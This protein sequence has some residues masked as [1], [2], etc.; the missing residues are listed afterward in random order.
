MSFD[1]DRARQIYRQLPTL[2][3][4]WAEVTERPQETARWPDLTPYEFQ[5]FSQNGEDGIVCEIFRRIGVRSRN[6]V[7]FGTDVGKEGNCIFLADVL[8][9]HG[10][11]MEGYPPF[12]QRLAAKYRPTPEVTTR[13]ILVTAD[14]I[15]RLLSEAGVAD[16]IDLLSIDVDGSDLWIWQAMTQCRPRVVVVEFNSSIPPDRSLAQAESHR[17]SWDGSNFFGASVA[18]LTA[19]G[20]EK[21]YQLVYCELTGTNLF[22]VQKELAAGFVDPRDVRLRGPNYYLESKGHAPDTRNRQ[23]TEY[24]GGG[25]K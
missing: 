2:V 17:E 11:F 21:G 23:Y 7:E 19:V 13:N 20:D 3:D 14:N 9:W 4:R 18:A 10:L 12:Y 24:R 5:T 22:F 1:T 6:F 15:E 16:D 25:S 8:G